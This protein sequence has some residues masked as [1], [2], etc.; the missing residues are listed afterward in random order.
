MPRLTVL[1]IYDSNLHSLGFAQKSVQST[2]SKQTWR[3]FGLSVDSGS[4]APQPAT[5][6]G[7][8][9]EG[10]TKKIV[11]LGIIPKPVD[12]PLGTVRN[13]NV[14]FGQIKNK[15]VNFMAKNNGH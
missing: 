15:I 10:S 1:R 14:E 12:L 5:Q 13:K 2:K 7:C 9:T 4:V 11:F 6:A 3:I 8:P